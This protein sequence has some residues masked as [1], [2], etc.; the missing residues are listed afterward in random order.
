MKHTHATRMIWL[1]LVL[2]GLPAWAAPLGNAAPP[3]DVGVDERLGAQVP[4]GLLFY[5]EQGR[6]VWLGQLFDGRP[7]VLVPAY[8][9]C[10]ML[11][12]LVLSNTSA[13]LRALRWSPSADFRVITVSFDPSDGPPRAR[14]KQ[15]AVL[16]ELGRGP[17]EQAALA[18]A[19]P[20][21]SGSP[22]EVQS[23]LSVLGYRTV[24]DPDGRQIA[25]PAA[26]VILTPS[27]RVSRYL[28]GLDFGAQDLRLAVYEAHDEL[29][30]PTLGGL[31]LRCYRYDPAIHRYALE[32]RTLLRAGGGFILALFAGL[33]FWVWRQGR[34]RRYRHLEGPP[35]PGVP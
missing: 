33:L 35:A 34:V 9:E 15:A 19:W 28:Y 23:L 24:A 13:V 16:D 7:V 12:G 6:P 25:H 8:F 10:P 32:V 27:G 14:R 1:L 17:A 21:L 26:I 22:A 4:L 18:R 5:D 2:V 11:C 29:T 3:P 30:R 31:L 20:F